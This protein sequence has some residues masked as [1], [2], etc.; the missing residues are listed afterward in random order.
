MKG[1]QICNKKG[2]DASYSLPFWRYPE[3]IISPFDD[4]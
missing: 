3:K 2:D 4:G 1:L